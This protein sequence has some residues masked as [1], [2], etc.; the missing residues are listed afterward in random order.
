MLSSKNKKLRELLYLHLVLFINHQVLKN[1]PC[2]TVFSEEDIPQ[3]FEVYVVTAQRWTASICLERKKEEEF[4]AP[5]MKSLHH[6]AVTT[7]SSKFWGILL[8]KTL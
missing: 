4:I 6:G 5:P 3:N 2:T 8:L 1:V 7:Y